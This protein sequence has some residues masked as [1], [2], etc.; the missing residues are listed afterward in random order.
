MN[1]HICKKS[2]HTRPDTCMSTHI[3]T[4]RHTPHPPHTSHSLHTQWLRAHYCP[5]NKQEE[6]GVNLVK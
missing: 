3:Y 6:S 5:V 2:A 4:Q 1:T